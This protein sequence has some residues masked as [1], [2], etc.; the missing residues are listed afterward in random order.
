M[1][2]AL[3][4]KFLVVAGLCIMGNVI[5]ESLDVYAPHITYPTH[6]VVWT[7]GEIQTV[8]WFVFPLPRRLTLS[9]KSSPKEYDQRSQADNEP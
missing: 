7:A 3:N 1:I 5:A 4:V 2:S 6:G 9:L 8:T